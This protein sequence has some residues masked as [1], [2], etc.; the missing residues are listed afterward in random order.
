MDWLRVPGVRRDSLWLYMS[1]AVVGLAGLIKLRQGALDHVLSE[2][3]CYQSVRTNHDAGPRA[4]N[5]FSVSP[6]G[7]FSDVFEADAGSDLARGAHPGHV[8]PGLW[9]GHGHLLQYG[10]FL[11]SVDLFGASSIDEALA[12]V[13]EYAER[14]PGAGS[15]GEWLRG[16]GWDQMTLGKT[17]LAVRWEEPLPGTPV[18]LP[19]NT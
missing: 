1:A 5:C 19:P 7:T 10:E 4:V 6:S 3:H 15:R 14:N 17:P 12:R 16:V 2:T 13:R 8:I 11:N 9:D 18:L